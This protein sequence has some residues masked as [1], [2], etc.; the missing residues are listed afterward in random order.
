MS[1][2]G[3]VHLWETRHPYHC[4]DTN[5]FAR[6]GET[7]MHFKSWAEFFAEEG[8]ADPDYNLLFRWDWKGQD[9]EDYDPTAHDETY[10]DGVL[11]LFWIGQR[12][13]LFRSNTVDVC[14]ADEPAVREWLKPRLD[15][16]LKLWTP[17]IPAT[18]EPS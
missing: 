13:G 16:L 8:D 12:K 17:L 18:K 2:P 4:S 11:H 5:Y 6:P 7:S 15:H 10:R 3:M 9:C 1:D 14:R